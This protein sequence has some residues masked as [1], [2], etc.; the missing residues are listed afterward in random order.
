MIQR[1]GN[2]RQRTDDLLQRMGY[3]YL[4][5]APQAGAWYVM[6]EDTARV[7]LRMELTSETALS[8]EQLEETQQKVRELFLHPQG[9]IAGCEH[10]MVIYDI[11]ML[12]LLITGQPDTAR[13]LCTACRNVWVMD[14]TAHRLMIYENQPGA[15]YGLETYLPELWKKTE[16]FK[17]LPFVNLTIIGM[18]LL[19]FLVMSLLGDTESGIFILEHGGMYPLYVMRD[20]EWWRLFTSMFLHFGIEHLANNMLILLFVGDTLERTVGRVRYLMIYLVSGFFGGLLSLLMMVRLTDW[21]VAAGASGAIFGV[22]G[23]LLWIV[24]RNRGKLETFTTKR[25][26]LMIVLS[27][28]LGFTGTGVDNWCHIGGLLGGFVLSVLL[29][30]RRNK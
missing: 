24:I 14:E 8:T 28:Y 15:F 25:M 20:G 9:R 5:L 13:E 29:Y 7:V 19:V 17:S 10:N 16:C 23:A 18:N 26:I 27:L 21:G 1:T 22:I 4:A 11:S 3:Q 2:L 6:E 12:T 30:R